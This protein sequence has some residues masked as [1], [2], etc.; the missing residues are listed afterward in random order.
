ME[1]S[2]LFQGIYINYPVAQNGMCSAQVCTKQ[3]EL[4][5]AANLMVNEACEVEMKI[6]M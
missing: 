6:T 1:L 2:T 5:E 4:K 3:G